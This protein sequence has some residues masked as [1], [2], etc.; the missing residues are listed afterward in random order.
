[1]N[2]GTSSWHR[3]LVCCALALVSCGLSQQ[4][5]GAE[6]TKVLIV[7]GQNNHDFWP[8]TTM[9]MKRYFEESGLF[10]VDIA[11]TKYTWKGDE[12]LGRYP[13]NDGVNRESLKEPKADPDFAP[14]FSKYQV[15]VSNFGNSAADW[16]EKTKV[17]FEEFVGK[18]GGFVAV[19]AA[20]NSFG[21]WKEYNLMTGLGGWG[22]RNDKVG[23]YVFFDDSGK[24]IRDQSP[25]KVGSH[26]KQHPFEVVIR[27]ADHPITK[28]LPRNWMHAQDE[29]YDKLRGP[30]ESMNVLATAFAS[31]SVGGTD[32][33]EPVAMTIDYKQGRVFHSP[34]GHAD[35]S[36]ECVGFITLLLR[37][38]EWA[39][40]GKVT[41]QTVPADFPTIDKESKRKFD[42]P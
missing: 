35:Y 19:H 15:V 31:K 17:A 12:W 28:G 37:G 30:A 16:P 26:G 40:T 36:F 8:K 4:S 42:G 6:R 41:Q 11:R 9:M 14:D 2:S 39:A 5:V 27:D 18:G 23:L 21:N 38:T 7:D 34:L 32:R 10:S 29:L 33:H 3:A 25:G 1:M 24:M 13:L 22:G 20:D